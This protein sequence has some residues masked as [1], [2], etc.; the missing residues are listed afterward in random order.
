MTDVPTNY[1]SA[2]V[3][4]KVWEASETVY[5]ILGFGWHEAVY[6]EALAAE[7]RMQGCT[8]ETEVSFPVTYKGRPLSYVFFRVDM[9][10][11]YNTVV[12][13]KAIRETSMNVAVRQCERY[14]NMIKCH[15]L[16]LNFTAQEGSK[17][18]MHALIK[19]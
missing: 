3:Q 14:M 17:V 19:K 15:G 2:A 10:V 4:L 18:S 8:V 13:L 7:L 1:D 16:V 11:N 12:E 9:L 5:E 6:R